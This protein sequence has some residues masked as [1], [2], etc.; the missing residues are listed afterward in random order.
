MERMDENLHQHIEQNGG[1]LSIA[2]IMGFGLDVARGLEYLQPIGILHL[3]INDRSILI[4]NNDSE[5]A[6]VSDF[7]VAKVL[8]QDNVGREVL[9]H[10]GQLF[11]IYPMY[12]ESSKVSKSSLFLPCFKFFLGGFVTGLLELFACFLHT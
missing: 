10:D 9:H 6:K 4:N 8:T 3:G 11:G 1:S 2:S 5:I 12:P 7:G